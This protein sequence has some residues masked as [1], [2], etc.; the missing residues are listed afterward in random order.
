[1]KLKD[2]VPVREIDARSPR[3]VRHKILT[4]KEIDEIYAKNGGDMQQVA[5]LSWHWALLVGAIV[6]DPQW[7]GRESRGD[8]R[9]MVSLIRS[10]VDQIVVRDVVWARGTHPD[11]FQ[12]YEW[13]AADIFPG[14]LVLGDVKY[15]DPR[16][17]VEGSAQFEKYQTDY[18]G[19]GLM[20]RTFEL[21][22]SYAREKSLDRIALSAYTASHAELFAKYG[23]V[24]DGSGAA[25]IAVRVGEGIPMVKPLK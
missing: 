16:R 24:P 11:G 6:E 7:I 9:K 19:Y 3:P 17:P 23:F 2:A 15:A 1:M 8:P 25:K 14:T 13:L 12:A 20:G 21:L 5:F 4:K 22:E 10:K 18:R